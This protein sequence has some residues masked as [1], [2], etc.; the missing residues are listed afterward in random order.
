M[1]NDNFE[2]AAVVKVARLID[3]IEGHS[4]GSRVLSKQ[5]NTSDPLCDGLHWSRVPA[6][7]HGLRLSHLVGFG[8]VE[9]AAA[10]GF[11][12]A[13]IGM[14]KQRRARIA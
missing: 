1:G 3:R 14:E 12:E 13:E 6:S 4:F 7:L 8:I 11:L 10:G 9:M 2:L 5:K